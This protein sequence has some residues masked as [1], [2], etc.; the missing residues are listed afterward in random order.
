MRKEFAQSVLNVAMHD[1][2]VI[3]LTGDLGFM[4]LEELRDSLKERFINCGVAEQNMVSVAAGLA[5]KGFLPF[6]YSIAP[7]VTLRPYEQLRNDVALQNLPVT[8]VGNGGGYGYGIMGATHHVLEDICIMQALPNIR[9]YVPSFCSDVEKCLHAALSSSRPAYLRL[10]KSVKEFGLVSVQSPWRGCRRVSSGRL[11]T[12]V[13]TGPVIEHVISYLP[14]LPANSVDLFSISEFPLT[15][16]D[17]ELA[18]SISSTKAVLTIEEHLITGG[19]AEGL[20]RILLSL[21][22]PTRKFK[23]LAAK[24]YPSGL[25]GSQLWHQTESELAGPLLLKHL[26]EALEI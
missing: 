24:G 10:G 21:G 20:A 26:Q 5:A 8:V 6:V 25:Y 14:S 16:L 22:I 17:D 13:A 1:E 19:L 2:R 7:F 18:R 9:V 4:A 12:V 11:L 15:N 3:F 23:S